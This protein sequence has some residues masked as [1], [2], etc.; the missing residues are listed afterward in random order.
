M[1]KIGK[2]DMK[3]YFPDMYKNLYEP[4][5]T[6]YD[7]EQIKKEMRK[8]KERIKREIKDQMYK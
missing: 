5:G 1:N 8:E 2:E 7:A 3:R 4:G 6:L